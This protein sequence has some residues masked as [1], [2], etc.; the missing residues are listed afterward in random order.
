MSKYP[1]GW[2]NEQIE[3]ARREIEQLPD[4]LKELLEKM[5][6]ILEVEI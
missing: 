5:Y 3:D 4:W 1:K 6:K 2:L